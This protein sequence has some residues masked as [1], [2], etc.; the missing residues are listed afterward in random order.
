VLWNEEL[1]VR[2]LQKRLALNVPIVSMF[3][4]DK[5]LADLAGWEPQPS[6]GIGN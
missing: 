3:S 4:N 2:R 5:R 6:E 1:E